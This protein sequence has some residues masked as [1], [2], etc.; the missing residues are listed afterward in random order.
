MPSGRLSEHDDEELQLWTQ[1]C[2]Q[3]E[4]A[5][6]DDRKMDQGINII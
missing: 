6:V 5:Q 2:L 3:F 1:K 4:S